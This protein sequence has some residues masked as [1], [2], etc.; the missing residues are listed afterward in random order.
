V[1]ATPAAVWP[2][3]HLGAM[4]PGSPAL[5]LPVTLLLLAGAFQTLRSRRLGFMVVGIVWATIFAIAG[6]AGSYQGRRLLSALP[7]ICVT[8]AFGFAWIEGLIRRRGDRIA[9]ALTL[10]LVGGLAAHALWA[11]DVRFPRY[12][13]TLQF[14]VYKDVGA[15]ARQHLDPKQDV[16]VLL[17]KSVMFPTAF[18]PETGFLPYRL[19]VMSEFYFPTLLACD[20]GNL[21][22]QTEEPHAPVRKHV[23]HLF[24]YCNMPFPATPFDV[25]PEIKNAAWRSFASLLER[26][27][28][29]GRHLYLLASLPEEQAIETGAL[30]LNSFLLRELANRSVRLET[31]ATFGPET[32]G[33]RHAIICRI[34][35]SQ[36]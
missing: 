6:V 22:P 19:I 32:T 15:Y 29:A 27:V 24:R 30:Q 14:S 12:L 16:I 9:G 8:A 17:D 28:R 33:N 5:Y 1:P 21:Y 13:K 11:L 36:G 4:L 34:S 2:F 26:E 7:F 31:L 25:A 35:L 20:T 23:P 3:D 18:Y 10:L